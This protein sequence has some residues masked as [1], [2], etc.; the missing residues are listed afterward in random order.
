MI[1]TQ[2]EAERLAQEK[3]DAEAKEKEEADRIAAEKV[4][5]RVE[6]NQ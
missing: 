2:A 4:G 3:A 6:N 5:A 1:A